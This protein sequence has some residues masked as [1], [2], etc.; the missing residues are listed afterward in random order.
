MTQR[1]HPALARY[2]ERNLIAAGPK[3]A[4]DAVELVLDD[5]YRVYCQPAPQGAMVFETRLC[6]LPE[7]PAAAAQ[8]ME[9]ALEYAAA[10]LA[11]GAEA[12]VLSE[13]ESGLMLQ[14]HLASD[15]GLDQFEQGLEDLTNAIGGWRRYLGV[16]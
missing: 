9:R 12:P 7:E 2:L 16:L 3:R 6:I 11:L 1:H 4:D 15:A 10:R 13:D 14:Q 8:M 5:I